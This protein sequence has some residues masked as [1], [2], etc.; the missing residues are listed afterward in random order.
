MAQTAGHFRPIHAYP[1]VFQFELGNA[2]R[3]HDGME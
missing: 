1:Q 2:N 3:D